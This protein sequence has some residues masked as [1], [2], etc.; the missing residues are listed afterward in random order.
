[1]ACLSRQVRRRSQTTI[2]TT[3]TDLPR[4]ASTSTKR[5]S[6]PRFLASLV[7]SQL[8]R[9]CQTTLRRSSSRPRLS[10]PLYPP[11]R[12]HQPSPGRLH[13]QSSYFSLERLCPRKS[14][15]NDD[16][17]GA[18]IFAPLSAACVA[19]RFCSHSLLRLPGQP[20]PGHPLAALSTI[21]VGS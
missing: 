14:Q 10:R 18:R 20:S 19:S 7:P 21:I 8:G 12:H 3:P 13:Q 16:G 1:P 9:L 17:R 4:L 15:K 5:E 11:R 6:L 2:S